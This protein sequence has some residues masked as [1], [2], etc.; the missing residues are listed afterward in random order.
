MKSLAETMMLMPT[1]ANRISTGY[2]ARMPRSLPAEGP[3]K[4]GG[5]IINA[6]IAAR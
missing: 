4:N 1:A 2:S 5:A 3:S 6:P